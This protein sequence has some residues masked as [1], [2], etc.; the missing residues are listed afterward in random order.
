MNKSL[1][2]IG[3]TG[4]IS[5]AVV[6]EALRQGYKVTCINRGKTKSQILPSE[7][8][9]LKSDYRNHERISQLLKGRIFDAV[10]DVL[11]FRK[12]DI[13]YS[14]SLFKDHCRQYFFFSSAEVYNKPKY[15]NTVINEDAEL[16]NP[17]WSY[18][19]NKAA[20]EEDLKQ[21]ASKY[22]ITYTI[23]R[24]AI[25]YGNTRIPYGVMPPYGYHGTIIQRLLHKKPIIIWDGG[26]ANAVITRVEDFAFGFVGLIGNKQ[27]YNQAFHIVG[28][29][30]YT[31]KAVIDTLGEILGE[32]PLYFSITKEEYA[33]EVPEKKG[34]ILGGRGIS[35]LLDNSKLKKVVPDFCTHISLKEGL[36]M[37]VDYYKTHNY[38]SGID[39]KFDAD[40]DRIIAKYCKLNNIDIKK[41]NLKF[42]DYLGNATIKNKI[43]YLLQYHKESYWS[44]L[45]SILIK[46][47]KRLRIK[48]DSVINKL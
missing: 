6:I 20:C 11:C 29:E 4:V 18:S 7:V 27:A 13:E 1:L 32:N 39:Y 19:L 35:Q 25:T 9:I 3:G 42:I 43:E 44:K 8:E 47:I 37:T 26:K 40:T 14:I 41:Y 34:E 46:I 30:R 23:V 22:N 15:E 48:I 17:L 12:E 38:L 5:Y 45:I 31:W 10:L 21:L 33:K 24:P 36:Q 2:V 16:G 28:D